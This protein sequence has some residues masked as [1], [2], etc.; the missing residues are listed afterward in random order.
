MVE[1]ATIAH[2]TCRANQGA[3]APTFEVTTTPN[4]YTNVR[5]RSSKETNHGQKTE[6]SAQPKCLNPNANSPAGS[7]TSD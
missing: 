3:H 5:S 7:S 6:N 1:L 4:R 2:D